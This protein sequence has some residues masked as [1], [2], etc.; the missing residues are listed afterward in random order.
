L[1]R[2]LTPPRRAPRLRRSLLVLPVVLGVLAGGCGGDADGSET[3]TAGT[4]TTAATA[5][6]EP[7]TTTATSGQ[8]AADGVFGRIPELVTQVSPSVVAVLVSGSEGTGTGSGVI[9]SSDGTI[10][11]NDHVVSG[12]DSIQVALA[13]GRRLDAEV[14]ATDPL[15]DLAVL[16]VEEEGL[17]AASFAPEL[18]D[19]GSLAVAIG[20]PLGLENTVTAG[21]VSGLHRNVPSGGGS[22]V[23][24]IQ[25]DAA[26]SPGNSGGALVDSDGR[27]IGINV[28][29]IPP[30]AR[31]VSI[32]FAIPS[33]TV[34]DVVSQLLETGRVQHA[35]LGIQP[36]AITPELAEQLDL[37]V[38]QGAIVLEVTEGSAADRAGLEPGD[39]I[40]AIG[41]ESIDRVEDLYS[42]LRRSRPGEQVTLAVVRDGESLELEAVLGERQG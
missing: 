24:L 17:P 34:V 27:V 14:V 38:E 36:S 18:P 33:P 5:T 6:T 3:T 4:T 42:V 8:V 20:T 21:I 2:S 39:V 16:R 15:S 26:I 22:L 41:E 31:A 40:T 11:T 13:S 32:G 23:D 25:T 29:Y 19:V 35:F 30:E 28:A 12:A 10:V 1:S 9:W 37:S 7:G